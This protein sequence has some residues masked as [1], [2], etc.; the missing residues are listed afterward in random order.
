MCRTRQQIIDDEREVQKLIE[1]KEKLENGQTNGFAPDRL[2][3]EITKLE[4]QIESTIREF[5]I[6]D[7]LD[8]QQTCLD[9]FETAMKEGFS[10]HYTFH[11]KNPSL[12]ALFKKSPTGVLSLGGAGLTATS[13]IYIKETRDVLFNLVG[14]KGVAGQELLVIGFPLFL[15]LLVTG[16]VAFVQAGNKERES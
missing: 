16:I 1:L 6:A 10:E 3:F 15:F 2:A 7:T 12:I 8:D 11:K 9:N 5:R 4:S 13:L 14:L